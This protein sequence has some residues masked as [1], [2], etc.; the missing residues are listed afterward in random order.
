M[1]NHINHNPVNDPGSIAGPLAITAVEDTEGHKRLMAVEEADE[2]EDTE[3][4]KRVMA[5]EEAEDT[6]GHKRLMMIEDADDTEGHG[7]RRR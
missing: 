2:T 5:V 7:G 6:E 1:S 4:H 3:G